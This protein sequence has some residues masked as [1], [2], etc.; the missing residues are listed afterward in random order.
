MVGRKADAGI[1]D[2]QRQLGQ[3][4][5]ILVYRD[6]NGDGALMGE[7]DGVGQQIVQHLTDAGAVADEQSARIGVAAS[8]EAQSLGLGLQPHHVQRGGDGLVEIEGS[9]FQ[10]QMPGLDLGY[11][12]NVGHQSLQCH[13]GACD[14]GDHLGLLGRQVGARQGVD[15]PD[16][17]VQGRADL[18]AHIG[19]E[20]GLRG[21]GGLGGGGGLAQGAFGGDLF[22]HV[23]R[24]AIDA[25]ALT[26][27][28]PFDG[29]IMAGLV[30]IAVDLA[31]D[32]IARPPV[33]DLD[34]AL[35]GGGMVVRVDQTQQALT[36]DLVGPI[37]QHGEPGGAGLDHAPIQLAHHQQI[38][39]HIEE[40]V[41]IDIGC[42]EGQGRNGRTGHGHSL[43]LRPMLRRVR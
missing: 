43:E 37:A 41:Q 40:G 25:V 39:R 32:R 29:D 21:I 33:F 38:Q 5:G 36:L 7:L 22:G 4:V 20:F 15:D 42:G 8:I 24:D 27:G 14:Q 1:L 13:A 19:Q 2:P 31:Q 3:A 16:H 35:A 18:V 10:V 30:A 12:Q 11:V 28:A 23:A 9:A 17:A 34:D 6:D 26:M